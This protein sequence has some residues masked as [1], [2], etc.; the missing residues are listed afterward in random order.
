M[1]AR[2]PCVYILASRP[3]GTLYIGVTSALRKRVWEHKTHAAKGFTDRYGVCRLVWYE[4]HETMGAAI[5]R[6]KALKAWQRAWKIRLIEMG[7]TG[8]R[9]LYDDVI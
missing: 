5:S 1:P 8:W 6:E 3:Q 4:V 9:D 7:N 2:M